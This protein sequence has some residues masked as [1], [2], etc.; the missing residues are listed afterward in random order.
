MPGILIAAWET[1]YRYLLL[2]L[3]VWAGVNRQLERADRQ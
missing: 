2:F 1:Q 3:T